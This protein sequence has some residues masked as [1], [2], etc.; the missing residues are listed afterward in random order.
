LRWRG[1]IN[2][3][4]NSQ[5]GGWLHA[6]HKHAVS[7]SEKVHERTDRKTQ[8]EL[9]DEALKKREDMIAYMQQVKDRL[10]S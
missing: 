6:T 3:F 5:L 2:K 1:F 10:T 4:L 9:D 7:V 8:K